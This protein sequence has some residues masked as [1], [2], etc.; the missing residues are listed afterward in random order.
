[1]CSGVQFWI[2]VFDKSAES[3]NCSHN[4][5]HKADRGNDIF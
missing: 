5:I 1:M 3:D 4:N 2:R